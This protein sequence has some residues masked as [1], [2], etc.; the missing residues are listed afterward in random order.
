MSFLA[1][2]D[3][4]SHHQPIVSRQVVTERIDTK[5]GLGCNGSNK[6]DKH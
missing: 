4:I 5:N 3:A 2:K 1:G 6:F